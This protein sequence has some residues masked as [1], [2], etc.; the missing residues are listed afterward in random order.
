MGIL[1]VSG[2]ALAVCAVLW[3]ALSPNVSAYSV[4]LQGQEGRI[5]D[6][7][8]SDS[9][10]TSSNLTV[11][12]GDTVELVLQMENNTPETEKFRA[13]FGL[14]QNGV[15]ISNKLKS[16]GRDVRSGFS[17]TLVATA[18]AG[19]SQLPVGTIA[20]VCTL[21]R[22]EPWFFHFGGDWLEHP[23]DWTGTGR[24]VDNVTVTVKSDPDLVVESI[25]ADDQDL[26]FGESFRLSATVRNQGSAASPGTTLRY[27][28]SSNRAI[29]SSGIDTEI[30]NDSIPGLSANRESD[31]SI[32]LIP[33]NAGTYYYGAC[34]DSVADE[35]DTGNNCSDGVRVTVQER[36]PGNL[37]VTP[38]EPL[39]G[40]S[41][42][43][44]GPEGGHSSLAAW[45]TP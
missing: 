17:A 30:G 43:S 42:E 28:R 26:E 24:P 27:Y 23:V 44:S 13:R 39:F 31:E 9:Y 1:A 18:E 33:L 19:S 8:A 38:P 11:S 4:H 25:R 41:F 36:P 3:L 15:E 2:L 37:E 34:A 21:E 10:F 12:E 45:Y 20:A 32:R 14:W 5:T 29:S 35:S 16:A 22:W 6:C 7:W 40:T